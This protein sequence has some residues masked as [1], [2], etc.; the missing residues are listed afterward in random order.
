M[1]MPAV[2]NS[3]QIAG[4]PVG[5]KWSD[6]IASSIDD[7]ENPRLYK[8]I[9]AAN[10]RAKM[11]VGAALAEWAVWRFNGLLDTSD[12]LLRVEAAW[13]AAIDPEYVNDLEFETTADDDKEPLLGA[14][15]SALYYLGETAA[16]Y[17]GKNIYLAE[18]VT[19]QAA[20]ARHV[21]PDKKKFEAWLNETLRRT[22]AAFPRT[23]EYDE[24]TE[25]YDASGEAPVPKAFFF[26]PQYVHS[27][28]DCR[29]AL[30]D[31]LGK[32]DPT[33][34]PYLRSAKEMAKH[35]FRGTAY[36]L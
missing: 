6:D 21:M 22:A 15:Q 36:R 25:Q 8:A 34:N 13:A 24:S 31:Y 33:R 7:T 16:D 29:K 27:D 28:A 23:S 18:S 1:D 2:I 9:D 14:Y 5:F 10:F 35:G 3:A 26:A 32:L 12:G 4:A 20:H 19:K 11:A 30:S 17:L